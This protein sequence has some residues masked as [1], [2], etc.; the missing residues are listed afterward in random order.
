MLLFL[1]KAE[2]MVLCQY[3]GLSIAPSNA[4]QCYG[5]VRPPDPIRAVFYEYGK[6]L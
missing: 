4:A 6:H 1:F 5:M 2:R 3:C